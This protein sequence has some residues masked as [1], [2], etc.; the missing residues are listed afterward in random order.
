MLK[1][2]AR[3]LKNTYVLRITYYLIVILSTFQEQLFQEAS[4]NACFCLFLRWSLFIWQV[5]ILVWMLI[6]TGFSR[7]I[8]QS[9]MYSSI[10]IIKNMWYYKFNGNGQ[11]SGVTMNCCSSNKHSS[12]QQP[13]CCILMFSFYLIGQFVLVF[14]R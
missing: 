6:F 13:D 3:I 9:S 10:F 8:Q 4:F 12:I 7:K 11:Y 5:L 14:Q 2:Y 1:I